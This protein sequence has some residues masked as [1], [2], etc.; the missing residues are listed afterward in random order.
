MTKVIDYRPGRRDVLKMAG[1]LAVAGAAMNKGWAQG[2]P[3]KI[4][5]LNDQNGPYSDQAGPGSV[6]AVKM[7][8]EDCGGS[9]L[10]RQVEVVVGDHQNKADIGVGIAREWFGPGNVSMITDFANSSIALGVRELLEPNKK[11]GLFTGV[12][13]T[14]LIGKACSP[15]G[16]L[17]AHDTWAISAGLVR[18][19]MK[20]GA[21]KFY[22]ITADYA[23]GQS[24]QADATG[25][26]EE[27]GGEVLGTSLH[28]VNTND[29]SSFLLAARASG[30]DAVI[31][32]NAGADLTNCL[33]QAA[34]FGVTKKQTVLTP[35]MFIVDVHSLGLEVAQGL[36][37]TQ[38]FYWDLNEETRAWS[39][40][41]FA[42]R[43]KMASDS[44]VACYSATYQYLKAIERAKSIE[45]DAV[46]KELRAVTISD[47]FTK[48]GRIREDGKMVFDRYLVR[49]KTPEESKY[50]WDY[51]QIIDKI[52]AEQAFRPLALSKECS[53]DKI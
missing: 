26:I 5:V 20:Q 18:A 41:F 21:K 35:L 11:I 50:D 48:S 47:V 52:P 9:V 14:Q 42:H 10:G 36:T 24:L 12:S 40:R 22:F 44:Q 32:A 37:F 4:G 16:V 28:P 33:K 17:W 30:A 51:L 6:V 45:A 25:A 7:A 15:Y 46:M 39:K 23:F 8:V 29:F 19:A 2:D 43:K 1:A 31:L 13:T 3:I 38:S 49:V 27:G 53:M 34:E